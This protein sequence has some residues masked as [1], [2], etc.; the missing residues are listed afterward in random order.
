MQKRATAGEGAPVWAAP[1]VGLNAPD[2]WWA[3][4]RAALL[5]YLRIDDPSSAASTSK[6]SHGLG[7]WSKKKEPQKP[8]VSYISM[9]EQ[10]TSMGPRLTGDDHVQLVTGLR[11][12]E[13]E[14]VVEVHV[15]NGNGSVPA[16]EWTERMSAFAQS[17][18]SGIRMAGCRVAHGDLVCCR[19]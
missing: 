16:L 4:M 12:L 13:Q 17:T 8:V 6:E 19:S 11:K 10:P 15:V 3:P 1:F 5:R 2:G 14:G 18:V 7:F 9:Q